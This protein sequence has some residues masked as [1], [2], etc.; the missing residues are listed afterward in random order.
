LV[1]SADGGASDDPWEQAANTQTLPIATA[2][3]IIRA[4]LTHRRQPRTADTVFTSK[5]AANSCVSAGRGEP[6]SLISVVNA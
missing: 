2:I 3:R 5:S 4:N 6:G 1:I